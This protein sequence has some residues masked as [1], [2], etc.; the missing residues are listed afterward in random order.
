VPIAKYARPPTIGMKAM[1]QSHAS[2]ADGRFL[3]RRRC[4]MNAQVER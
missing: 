2:V 4:G 1:A 3:S